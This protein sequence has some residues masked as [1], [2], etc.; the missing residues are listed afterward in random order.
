MGFFNI[1]EKTH[2]S[3]WVGVKIFA[4]NDPLVSYDLE[5]LR[6]S[7]LAWLS[8]TSWASLPRGSKWYVIHQVLPPRCV[9]PVKETSRP[10]QVVRLLHGRKNHPSLG[11]NLAA[12]R[13]RFSLSVVG[14]AGGSGCFFCWLARSQRV[15]TNSRIGKVSPLWWWFTTDWCF[16]YRA[17]TH[18]NW[19]W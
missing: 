14:C 9:R 5:D 6:F 16:R 10:M 18:L 17:I 8:F 13:G 2:L 15:K 1:P 7:K 3:G 12:R 19:G 4:K 11:R